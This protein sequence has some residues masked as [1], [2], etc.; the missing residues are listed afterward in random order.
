MFFPKY[1][2]NLG[3]AVLK[4]PKHGTNTSGPSASQQETVSKR[5]NTIATPTK[6]STSIITH[7]KPHSWPNTKMAI[8]FPAFLHT[9][10]TNNGKTPI[11]DEHITNTINSWIAYHLLHR[12]Y[13]AIYA[14]GSQWTN[15]KI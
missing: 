2:S 3:K 9:S 10:G 6:S 5:K 7:E 15:P 14:I 11:N 12:D 1:L 8:N 4:R 13:S